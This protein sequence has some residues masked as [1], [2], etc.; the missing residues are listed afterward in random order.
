[1]STREFRKLWII[2]LL[3]KLGFSAWLPLFSDE[4]YYWVWSH[5]PQLSVEDEH[6]PSRT[7]ATVICTAYLCIST[8]S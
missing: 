3:F 5:H 6:A 8:S 1:M 7:S 2:G 4:A